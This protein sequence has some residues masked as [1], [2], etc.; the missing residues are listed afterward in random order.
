MQVGGGSIDLATSGV[1]TGS[2]TGVCTGKKLGVFIGNTLG[3]FT[4]TKAS[5]VFTGTTGVLIGDGAAFDG[6]KF[7]MS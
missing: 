6:G 7:K 5:E 2:T 4:C 3:V 1:L